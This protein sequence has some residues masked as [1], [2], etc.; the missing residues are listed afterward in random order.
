MI[1]DVYPVSRIW[2]SDHGIKKT[3]FL[4]WQHRY[5][6]LLRYVLKQIRIQN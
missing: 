6:L 5:F 2:I 3:L 4:D 1:R